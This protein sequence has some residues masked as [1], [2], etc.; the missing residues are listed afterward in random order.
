ML[1]SHKSELSRLFRISNLLNVGQATPC[2]DFDV[3]R[4]NKMN[5]RGQS[6]WDTKAATMISYLAEIAYDIMISP[7]DNVSVNPGFE[8]CY[9]VW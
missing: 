6:M 1:R 2:Q 4:I 5:L 9:G 8:S 3:G 7:I